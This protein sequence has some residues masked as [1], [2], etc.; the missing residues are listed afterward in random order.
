MSVVCL[1]LD[2]LNELEIENN[3]DRIQYF[4]I[5]SNQ[6]N[7]IMMFDS[8]TILAALLATAVSFSDAFQPPI[9]TV[10]GSSTMRSTSTTV[11]QMSTEA[12]AKKLPGTAKMD[13]PWEKL[14]FEFR[15]TNSHV[16]LK[17]TEEGGWSEPEIIK[18]S[19]TRCKTTR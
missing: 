15:P 19:L 4:R 9:N 12:A 14:G 7:S 1:S 17:W 16:Q 10:V 2:T 13:K 6:I 11:L 18:V 5:K 3:G 8:R